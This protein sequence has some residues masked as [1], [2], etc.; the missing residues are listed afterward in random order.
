MRQ[1][2]WGGSGW[3]GRAHALLQQERGQTM[4]EYA[5]VLGILIIAVVGGVTLFANGVSAKLQADL[6]VILSGV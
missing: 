5:T 1:L 3:C 2:V 6:V 4:A